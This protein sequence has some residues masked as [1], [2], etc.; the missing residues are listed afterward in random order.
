MK[1][2]LWSELNYQCRVTHKHGVAVGGPAEGE[3][4]RVAAAAARRPRRRGL[5]AMARDAC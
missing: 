4:C 3:P 1:L 2:I 5:I